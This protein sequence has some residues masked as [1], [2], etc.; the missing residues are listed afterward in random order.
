MNPEPILKYEPQKFSKISSNLQHLLLFALG[1]AI[2]LI[3]N[4][5]GDGTYTALDI[6]YAN[7][8]FRSDV[9]V[10]SSVFNAFVFVLKQ[11]FV[12]L[13]AVALIVPI[14]ITIF[15]KTL[16]SFILI[17][18]GFVFFR[19][20]G[21]LTNL[22]S[23]GLSVEGSKHLILSSVIALSAAVFCNIIFIYLCSR[24]RSFS[25][26]MFQNKDDNELSLLVSP[27]ASTFAQTYLTVF[28]TV[29]IISIFKTFLLW[30]ISLI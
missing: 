9:L 10:E 4:L 8:T 23:R 13:I 27:E 30:I 22:C 11:N 25:E 24:A 18:K 28:G 12:E 6:Y 17:L 14:C 16:I 2:A 19:Y 20:A 3:T 1:V 7:L 15:S 29:I 26:H 21:A 5:I